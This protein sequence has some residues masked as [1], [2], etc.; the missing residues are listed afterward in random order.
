MPG[1]KCGA[2]FAVDLRLLD[3]S[4]SAGALAFCIQGE[5]KGLRFDRTTRRLIVVWFLGIALNLT[6]SSV[7]QQNIPICINSSEANRVADRYI[8]TERQ[9]CGCS[10][11]SIH[12][13]SHRRL[14]T[15]WRL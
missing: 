4:A 11:L 13:R 14:F 5:R 2:W 6:G 12:V 9:L 7:F 15:H 8:S 1:E 3:R 10:E